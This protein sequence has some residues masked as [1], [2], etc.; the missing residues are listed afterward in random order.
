[1]C[2]YECMHVCMCTVEPENKEAFCR[3]GK[4]K[5]PR[6]SGVVAAR[7]GVRGGGRLV[8]QDAHRSM[9]GGIGG[10]VRAVCSR[11]D[12]GGSGSGGG[13]GGGGGDSRTDCLTRITQVGVGGGRTIRN[14]Y[15]YRPNHFRIRSQRTMFTVSK[16]IFLTFSSKLICIYLLTLLH[17]LDKNSL[18]INYY[19]KL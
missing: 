3:S 18:I 17:K 19:F 13:G 2:V 5:R 7:R 14:A 10:G 1:M 11:P 8:A 6:R 15:G 9:S 12:G 4:A 16:I